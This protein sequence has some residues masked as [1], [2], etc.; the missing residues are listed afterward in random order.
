[1]HSVQGVNNTVA[2]GMLVDSVHLVHAPAWEVNSLAAEHRAQSTEH[3]RADESVLCS[4]G[5]PGRTGRAGPLA[6][7]AEYLARIQREP[8]R[9]PDRAM[10]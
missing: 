8:R 9:P 3:R 6:L 1:M 2:N 4:R 10:S 7:A 5:V